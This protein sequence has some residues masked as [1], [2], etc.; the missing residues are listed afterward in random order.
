MNDYFYLL[1]LSFPIV[2]FVFWYVYRALNYL[3]PDSLFGIVM[4]S[5]VLVSVKLVEPAKRMSS[6]GKLTDEEK[7]EFKKIAIDGV[8]HELPLLSQALV[9]RNH[10]VT[11]LI[12]GFI[13]VALVMYKNYKTGTGLT[14]IMDAFKGSFNFSKY[15]I[16]G[17]K[18]EVFNAVLDYAEVCIIEQ[19][20]EKL[21]DNMI[22]AIDR[23][24]DSVDQ[25][26]TDAKKLTEDR[27]VGEI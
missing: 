27:I 5:V 4:K 18:R 14:G 16:T 21:S 20:S 1:L 24:K 3:E 6:D 23:L 9:R 2:L 8:I 15:G 22:N 13:E 10:Q 25:L 12:S 26:H 7:Q 17:L 19:E 11:D